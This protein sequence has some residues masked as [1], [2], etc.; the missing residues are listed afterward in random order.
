MVYGAAF[1]RENEQKAERSKFAPRRGQSLKKNILWSILIHL[2]VDKSY[3]IVLNLPKMPEVFSA[4]L[5]YP[6]YEKE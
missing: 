3:Y 4:I 5:M 2:T 1:E 6:G